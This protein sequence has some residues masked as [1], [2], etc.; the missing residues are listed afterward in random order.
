MTNL[1]WNAVQQSACDCCGHP[2]GQHDFEGCEADWAGMSCVCA[3]SWGID[4][5]VEADS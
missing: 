2:R 4:A 3:V 1:D 5:I